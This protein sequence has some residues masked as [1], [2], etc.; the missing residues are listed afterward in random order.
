MS[1][2]QARAASHVTCDASCVTLARSGA[3]TCEIEV[4]LNDGEKVLFSMVPREGSNV[5]WMQCSLIATCCRILDMHPTH[6]LSLTCFPAGVAAIETLLSSWSGACAKAQ[7]DGDS[8]GSSSS[9]DDSE[10]M[11][12]DDESASSSGSGS[13]SGSEDD[14]GSDGSSGSG[15]SDASDI[16]KSELEALLDES[17]DV[18]TD[19]A[20]GGGRPTKRLR[21]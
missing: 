2:D 7:D 12:S 10:Y 11:D 15:S 18:L 6:T 21:R 17:R 8:D 5:G 4:V 13:G 9:D 14:S 16:D 1:T 20:A 3:S 19:G